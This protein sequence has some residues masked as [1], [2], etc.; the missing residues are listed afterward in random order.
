[1]VLLAG[2]VLSGV[3]TPLTAAPAA[4]PAPT[5]ASTPVAA[6]VQQCTST[7]PSTDTPSAKAFAPKS[8]SIPG[9]VKSTRVLARG[10]EAGG[11]PAAPPLTN[12]GKWQFS[13]DRT[14][15]AAAPWGV[16]RLT[17]HTYPAS[18]G[19][20][21]GNRLLDRLRKGRILVVTG[22]KG[23]RTCYRVTKRVSVPANRTY[24]PY[25]SSGEHRLGIIV[26]SGVRRGPGNWSRRTVWL[27]S[28]IR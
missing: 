25:Y 28:P 8:I 2:V 4:S 11:V 10:R 1:V 12:T 9:V 14:V 26:C 16:V 7:D 27:A 24:V 15:K 21:L 19:V 20:A 23:V 3:L 6:R 5:D 18:A 17:A 22:P 13:W